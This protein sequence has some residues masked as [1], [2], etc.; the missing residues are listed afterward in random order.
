M[1]HYRSDAK[2]AEQMAGDSIG[3]LPQGI[4]APEAAAWTV[5]SNV[6]LSMDAVLTKG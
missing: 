2:A 4:E 1:E 6:L 5:V 3:P